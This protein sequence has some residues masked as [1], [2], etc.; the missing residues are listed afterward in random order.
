MVPSNFKTVLNS[1]SLLNPHPLF[2]ILVL[3]CDHIL[4]EREEGGVTILPHNFIENVRSI[5]SIHLFSLLCVWQCS[6][7][8]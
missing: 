4:K 5:Y 1:L 2:Y 7:H 6:K 8:V 3:I